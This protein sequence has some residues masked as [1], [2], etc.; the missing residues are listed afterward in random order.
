MDPC[1]H[2]GA[3]FYLEG[4]T[5]SAALPQDAAHRSVKRERSVGATVQEL[6]VLKELKDEQFLDADEYERLKQ[7]LLL[8]CS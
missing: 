6:T 8:E 3:T 1:G 2:C 5:A 7:K 4:L